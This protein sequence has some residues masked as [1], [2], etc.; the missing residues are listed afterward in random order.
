MR[1]AHPYGT[2]PDVPDHR[3]LRYEAPRHVRRSLPQRGRPEAGLPAGRGPAA[4]QQLLG[5]RDR[6]GPL[7]RE[8]RQGTPPAPP[9]R[10]F[11][12]WVERARE[13]TIGTNAPV[14]L[15]D[16][17]KAVGAHGVCPEPLWP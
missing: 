16:G 7:V 1:D 9:S 11:L 3:D 12:Y 6:R 4:A 5:P 10:L 2:H 15:R 13:H 8:S 17:Y 14:S